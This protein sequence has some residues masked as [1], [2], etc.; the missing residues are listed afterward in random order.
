[1]KFVI[2]IV[3]LCIAQAFAF[4]PATREEVRGYYGTCG[5][6]LNIPKERIDKFISGGLDQ[7]E[8]SRKVIVCVAKKIGN[9]DAS[10]NIVVD[11]LA[12][13]LHVYNP[14]VSVADLTTKINTCNAGLEGAAVV[15]ALKGLSCLKKAGLK[16]TYAE[17]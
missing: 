15:R 4:T 9:L 13:Q 2:A 10:D 17:L 16:T 6:E 1:M 5:T 7:E 11:N 8:D 14:D 3:A 12:K